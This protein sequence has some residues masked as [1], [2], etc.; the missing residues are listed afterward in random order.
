MQNDPVNSRYEEG[1]A[2]L[3]R[4]ITAAHMLRSS[5]QEMAYVHKNGT[6]SDRAIPEK[7]SEE[8]TLLDSRDIFRE[9]LMEHEA[10]HDAYLM[11][12]NQYK[13]LGLESD[14]S[15]YE[16]RA[17]LEAATA[18]GFRAVAKSCDKELESFGIQNTEKP[19]SLNYRLEAAQR[20]LEEHKN[21]HAIS[22]VYI[23]QVSDS[24]TIIQQFETEKTISFLSPYEM[25]QYSAALDQR[26]AYMTLAEE[27]AIKAAVSYRK[28]QVEVNSAEQSYESLGRQKPS[29]TINHDL[30]ESRSAG[31]PER[32]NTLSPER[33]SF[34]INPLPNGHHFGLSKAEAFR[35]M[36][37]DIN[38]EL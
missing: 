36:V 14:A 9:K 33:E 16:T 11:L 12:S 8:N 19:R 28:F 3:A 1:K 34:A 31:R 10:R 38:R 26:D 20:H 30:H 15:A 25:K 32:T 13:S 37:N 7:F 5:E 2:S 18:G 17:Q 22:S 23:R 27:A 6:H 4:L 24:Q 35:Q 21:S 29:A